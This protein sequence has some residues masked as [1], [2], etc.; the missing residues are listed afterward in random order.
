MV[1][2]FG[3]EEYDLIHSL[4]LLLCGGTENHNIFI[5]CLKAAT[6]PHINMSTFLRFNK[7]SSE[8]NLMYFLRTFWA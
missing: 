5:F 1:S 3:G 8:L 7:K 2:I 6:V 4:Q